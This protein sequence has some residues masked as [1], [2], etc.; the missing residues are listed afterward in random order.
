MLKKPTRHMWFWITGLL[1]GAIQ[2]HGQVPRFENDTEGYLRGL[3]RLDPL[4]R[5]Q[6]L[7]TLNGKRIDDK[8]VQALVERMRED[9]DPAV[10][11][12][13]AT[14]LVQRRSAAPAI[15]YAAVCD[16]NAKLRSTLAPYAD[17]QLVCHQSPAMAQPAPLPPERGA[18]FG[19]LLHPSAV[20]RLLALRK[21]ARTDLARIKATVWRLAGQ[22]PFW[23][24]RRDA[25]RLL[26]TA[27]GKQSLPLLRYAISGDP[28]QRVRQDSFALLAHLRQARTATWLATSARVETN[29]ALRQAAIAALI[30]L[31][32][33]AASTELSKLALQHSDGATR[34]AA[35]EALYRV[36]TKQAY[37]IAAS[38]AS[39]DKAATVRAAALRLLARASGPTACKARRTQIEDREPEVR[40]AAIEQLA[41]CPDQLKTPLL[42]NA[43]R[44]DRD[45]KVRGAA[46]AQLIGIGVSAHRDI[47]GAVLQSDRHPDNRR[48]VLEAL[49]RQGGKSQADSE[50]LI[51]ASKRERDPHLRRLALSGLGQIQSDAAMSALISALKSDRQAEVRSEAARQLAHQRGEA[52]FAALQHVAQNDGVAEVRAAAA[53]AMKNSPGRK[54]WVDGLLAQTIDEDVVVRLDAARRLCAL[55]LPRSY[56]ALVRLLWLDRETKARAM[57]ARC[58][59]TLHSPLIDIALSVAHAVDSDKTVLRAIET[60][61]QKRRARD[62]ALLKL[63]QTATPEKRKQAIDQLIPGPSRAVRDAL[64]QAMVKDAS[65]E[66]RRAAA[67][68]VYRYADSRALAKL[69]TASQSD[70][71]AATRSYLNGLY[72][73]LRQRRSSASSAISALSLIGKLRKLRGQDAQAAAMLLAALRAERARVPLEHAAQS[74]DGEK[75]FGAL[76]ALASLTD[77]ALLGAAIRKETDVA[78]RSKLI[79]VNLLRSA[80]LAKLRET[81]LSE[82]ST[83]VL[84]A[85]ETLSIRSEPELVALIARAALSNLDP[86]VRLAAARTLLLYRSPLAYWTVRVAASHDGSP[87]LRAQIWTFAVVADEN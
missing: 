51:A 68:K 3:R 27:Y 20:T 83:E 10:R 13:A 23:E 55:Q 64:E 78:V 53:Q 22:D 50:L 86:R 54:A 40:L 6:A 45:D 73:D 59:S 63:L 19:Y 77:A 79:Q 4:K 17:K 65:A 9:V 58:F 36:D 46:I 14:L 52:V 74:P 75:R 37:R 7:A 12:A 43:A 16:P 76:L 66:V 31:P 84:R 32:R 85:I 48:R 56:R 70:S 34:A 72:E 80:P 15:A 11:A 38:A 8:L 1:F 24:F 42:R 25:L 71:E 47:L 39:T 33:F 5:R 62:E 82:D 26:V 57:L 18:T 60:A 30:R 69:M 61:Q 28:D 35:L 67:A 41:G 49:L 29:L 44:S 2:A 87:K 81:L 21:L